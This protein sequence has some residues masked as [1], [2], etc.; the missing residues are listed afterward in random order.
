MGVGEE[1]GIQGLCSQGESC[2][3]EFV[4]GTERTVYPGPTARMVPS[5]SLEQVSAL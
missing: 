1:M 2:L 5:V 3:F 4:L